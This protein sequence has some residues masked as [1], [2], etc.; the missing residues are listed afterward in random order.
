MTTLV[1]LKSNTTGEVQAVQDPA[2]YDDREWTVMG[3]ERPPDDNEEWDE[4][5]EAWVVNQALA[6]AKDADAE[7]RD[8]KRQKACIAQ[9]RAVVETIN[10][11]LASIE[12]RLDTLEG[13]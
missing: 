11:R 5:G 1:I 10:T 7:A 3:I 6:D 8:F 4:V 2:G 13:N 12:V 9:A